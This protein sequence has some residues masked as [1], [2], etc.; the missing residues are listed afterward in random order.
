MDQIRRE[1]NLFSRFFNVAA[2]CSPTEDLAQ[3]EMCILMPE[4]AI[5][6][7]VVLVLNPMYANY[8]DSA[9]RLLL[10]MRFRILN[11]KL[12][13]LQATEAKEL[14]PDK[15]QVQGMVA[16][17][18]VHVWHLAK[19]AGDREV[20]QLF[21]DVQ[22]EYMD[23]FRRKIKT[24]PFKRVHV[25][26]LFLFLDSPLPFEQSL[27]LLYSPYLTRVTG[28]HLTYK[29]SPREKQQV[30]DIALQITVGD[31]VKEL[32]LGRNGESG[33]DGEKIA[34]MFQLVGNAGM[35]TAVHY[36]VESEGHGLFEIRFT[37]VPVIDNDHYNQAIDPQKLDV[38]YLRQRYF[39][40]FQM[41]NL[42]YNQV[43]LRYYNI[44]PSFY[45]FKICPLDP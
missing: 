29:L 38:N 32:V 28:S 36:M 31:K 15:E 12:L 42:Y 44:C 26:Y 22:I 25:P 6:E 1:I 41:L 37:R 3:R 13:G 7:D 34:Q 24:T 39:T 23:L 2:H 4:T 21:K 35:S 20:R 40:R 10:R 14:F 30:L 16:D 19:I 8:Y 9:E 43:N 18:Q 33:K 27:S 17:K 11:H 45:R 5:I